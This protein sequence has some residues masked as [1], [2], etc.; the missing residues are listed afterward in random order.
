MANDEFENRDDELGELPE[1]IS[2]ER[3]DLADYQKEAYYVPGGAPPDV[4]EQSR[5]G[6]EITGAPEGSPGYDVGVQSVFDTRPINATD[7]IA[8]TNGYVSID[9]PNYT[10]L[11]Y[12]V[13]QGKVAI[14]RGIRWSERVNSGTI[15]EGFGLGTADFI[16][17]LAIDGSVPTDLVH[18][19][20]SIFQGVNSDWQYFHTVAGPGQVVTVKLV[21][22]FPSNG[23]S[24]WGHAE[25]R[26][27][28]ILTTGLPYPFEVG[29]KAPIKG[30][31]ALSPYASKIPAIETG[32]ESYRTKLTYAEYAQITNEI[33]ALTLEQ[34]NLRRQMPGAKPGPRPT[35]TAPLTRSTFEFQKGLW[36]K[37]MND[38][39]AEI[40]PLNATDWDAWA[41]KRRPMLKSMRDGMVSE[42][43]NVQA[44]RAE[45][46]QRQQR[47]S[48][49]RVR[50]LQHK[51]R[52]ETA[53]RREVY[54]VKPGQRMRWNPATNTFEYY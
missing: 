26:G 19:G 29:A 28:L 52:T 49:Q 34:W 32:E 5:I 51:G 38:P 53:A 9:S 30:S 20:V 46:A 40:P 44:K 12:I 35:G 43:I 7:F 8:A 37:F 50:E 39:V 4:A 11:T 17:V 25:I 31:G 1:D 13:P 23:G 47:S 10:A 42:R 36:D 6:G 16:T 54:G 14:I 45:V 22:S 41:K 48:V 15:L 21:N 33:V 18:D 24:Y 2:F 27:N 3:G